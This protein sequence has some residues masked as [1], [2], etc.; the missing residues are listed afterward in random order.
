[1][2]R[3]SKTSKPAAKFAASTIR[4]K[5]MR[6]CV[7]RGNTKLGRSIYTFSTLPGDADH[8]L[9]SKTGE[10]LCDIPGTC[11]GNCDACFAHG[12][13]AVNCA[14]RY[15]ATV[16]PAWARNTLL[17]R[18]RKAIPQINALITAKEARRPGSVRT[19]RINVSGEIQSLEELEAWDDLARKHPGTQFGLYTKNYSALA[20]F[21]EKHD[22]TA[23]NFVIN[24]SQ[25]NG[26]ANAALKNLDFWIRTGKV[27]VFEYDDTN[28]TSHTHTPEDVRRLKALQH[29]PAVSKTGKRATTPTGEP[30]TCDMCRRCYR[31]T[32]ATTAVYAH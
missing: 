18:E 22:S 14:R 17:M 27:N 5:D 11:T 28:R 26:V 30:I 1:M 24:V 32:G 7:T 21:L 23:P 13:Y 20:K 8:M 15:A 2:T 12:C 19:F 10:L 29:C 3:L 4:T 6:V 16:I 9:R 25:W 31:K